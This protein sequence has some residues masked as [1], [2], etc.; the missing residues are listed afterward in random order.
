MSF[1]RPQAFFLLLVFLPFFLLV[2]YDHG[3]RKRL[4]RGFLSQVAYKKLGIRS[5]PEIGVFKVVLI[6]IV[7]VFFITALAGPQWGT[8]LEKVDLEGLEMLFLLDTSNS[9]NAEDLKPNRLTVAKQLITSVVE[10]FHTDS[11][12]LVNFAGVAYVQCPLTIDYDAF[13]LM[14][15]ATLISPDEEQG[16]DFASAFKLALRSFKSTGEGKRVLILITDGEDQEGLWQEMIATLKE[17]RIIVFTVG[18]GV[19]DGAPIPVRNEAGEVSGWKKDKRG[20]IVKTRLDENTLVQISTQTGGQYFRLSDAAAIDIFI[21]NLKSFERSVLSRQVKL[22][23]VDR[24]HYP[25]ILGIIFLLL[26]LVLSE[27]RIPWKKD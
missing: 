13:K 10:G 11:V 5:G 9:M 22:K 24:F 4:Q 1:L 7:L 19:A 15:R 8:V 18:V 6:S 21:K 2:V 23:K 17:N 25:L 26:E 14:T 20:N 3:K 12:G 16:T 27:R